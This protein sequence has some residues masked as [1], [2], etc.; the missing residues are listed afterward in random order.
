MSNIL[1]SAILFN[2]VISDLPNLNQPLVTKIFN[3][4]KFQHDIVNLVA[5]N[6]T[7]VLDK[8]FEKSTDTYR[9]NYRSNSNS[10][11]NFIVRRPITTMGV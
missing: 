3:E 5:L 6:Y 8:L 2:R 7:H 10:T 1:I 4:N 11:Y 9:N